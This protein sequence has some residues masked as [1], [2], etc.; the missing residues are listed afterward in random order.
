MKKFQAISDP[1]TGKVTL[2]PPSIL[3]ID[4]WYN[5]FFSIREKFYRARVRIWNGGLL[6]WWHRLW[7]RKDEFDFSLSMDHELLAV[8]SP[9]EQEKYHN[10]RVIQMNAAHK[11]S[12]PNPQK[13]RIE[14]ILKK[15]K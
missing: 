12:D 3:S 13:S 10:N 11:K 5:L 14:K 6:L 4:W 15:Q 9:K 8:L 2:I 1:Q 7:I